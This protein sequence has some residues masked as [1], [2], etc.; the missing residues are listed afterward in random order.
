MTTFTTEIQPGD[1]S[2]Y[3]IDHL[4][5]ELKGKQNGS[6]YEIEPSTFHVTWDFEVE[7]RE[8][9]V[10]GMSWYV[11]NIEG[12]FDVVQFDE[13][14]DE[15]KVD[16]ITFDYAPFSDDMNIDIDDFSICPSSIDIDYSSD[17][18]EVN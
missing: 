17:S 2:I 5:P 8:W 14:G 10:K 4:L 18:I 12:T 9:G 6:D 16:T 1:V 11:T 7:T 13:K 3:G 15:V